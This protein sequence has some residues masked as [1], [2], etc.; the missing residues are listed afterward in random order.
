MKQYGVD[1]H[2][3]REVGDADDGGYFP[4]EAVIWTQNPSKT[5]ATLFFDEL[6]LCSRQFQERVIRNESVEDDPRTIAQIAIW[7]LMT[8]GRNSAFVWNLLKP[9]AELFVNKP[10]Y[11]A[12]EIHNLLPIWTPESAREDKRLQC[13]H[14]SSAGKEGLGHFVV[15]MSEFVTVN[16]W[17]DGDDRFRHVV[18]CVNTAWHSRQQRARARARRCEASKTKRRVS[19]R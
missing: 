15:R 13:V 12:N 5:V 18:E 8:G 9:Y 7:N 17:F 19:K 14:Q 4:I 16:G 11:V 1:P 2:H 10:I 3:I 6:S